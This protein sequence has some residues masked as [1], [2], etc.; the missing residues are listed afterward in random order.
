[1]PRD[2]L[3]IFSRVVLKF[4]HI[5]FSKQGSTNS[6]RR[7]NGSGKDS[8]ISIPEIPGDSYINTNTGDNIA[9]TCTCR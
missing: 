6:I 2:D 7:C 4:C 1:M 5:S 9:M 3:F 8:G